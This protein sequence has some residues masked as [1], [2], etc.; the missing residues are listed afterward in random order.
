MI[1]S[2][3][4]RAIGHLITW[5]W[6]NEKR[7]YIS[8]LFTSSTLEGSG[9]SAPRPGCFTPLK[10]LLPVVQEAGWVT[11]PVWMLTENFAYTM[12][13]SQ[14]RPSRSSRYMDYATPAA[15]L[16]NTYVKL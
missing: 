8:S 14:G 16:T 4:D 6:G 10:D 7:R 15:V 11:E 13:R 1:L 9:C 2:N 12:I 3:E 5:F